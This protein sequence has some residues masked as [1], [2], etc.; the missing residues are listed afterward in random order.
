M[1]RLSVCVLEIT[2]K[3][4]SH[5]HI[6]VNTMAVTAPGSGLEGGHAHGEL[7]AHGGCGEKY[8]SCV[9]KNDGR[10]DNRARVRWCARKV[11]GEDRELGT[12]EGF[13]SDRVWVDFRNVAQRGDLKKRQAPKGISLYLSST[14]AK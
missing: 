10:R 7:E 12:R 2:Q 8:G 3:Q 9:R 5:S 6:H 4:H 13:L 11:R 14:H 1:L